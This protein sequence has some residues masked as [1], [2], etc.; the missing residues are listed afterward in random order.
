MSNENLTFRKF[1]ENV[2]EATY[3]SFCMQEHFFG[4]KNLVSNAFGI[5][6]NFSLYQPNIHELVDAQREKALEAFTQ[7]NIYSYLKELYEYAVEGIQG[8]SYWSDIT[9][10]INIY[11]Q[12]VESDFSQISDEAKL[13]LE[14]AFLRFGMDGERDLQHFNISNNPNKV[15]AKMAGLDERTVRNAASEGMFTT[16]RSSYDTEAIKIWL[17]TKKG[18]N[19][20][21]VDE[22][23]TGLQLQDVKTAQEFG[24]LISSQKISLGKM[25]DEKKFKTSH[26]SFSKQTLLNLESG[27]FDL[28]LNAVRALADALHFDEK[29]FLHCVMRVFFA[30]ELS[31]IQE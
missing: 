9:E 19:R 1:I 10:E 27:I 5:E 20:T 30:Y 24:Q 22:N 29:D 28:P 17:N 7:M 31:I 2:L 6:G 26:Y 25:F 18:F 15:I 8:K 13:I 21:K 23:N 14:M 12:H 11:F 16:D 4:P 3:C